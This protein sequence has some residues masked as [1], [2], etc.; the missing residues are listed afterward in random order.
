MG[1]SIFL[2][3]FF[4]LFLA[5]GVGVLGYGLRSYHYGKQ[6][7]H[8]PTV[9]G[10]IIT[11]DLDINSDDDATTYQAK[12]EYRYTPDMIERT[13][14][15]IAFGYSGSSG[16]RTKLA[17]MAFNAC[18]QLCFVKIVHRNDGVIFNARAFGDEEICGM[19]PVAPRELNDIFGAPLHDAK[20]CRALI[21]NHGLRMRRKICENFRR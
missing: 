21:G 19:P 12:V 10:T 18:A 20:Q 7:E 16:E 13:G 3:L 8:W 17:Q 5:V 14:K 1:G 15:T 4:G 6:A 11:S 2:T 9:P